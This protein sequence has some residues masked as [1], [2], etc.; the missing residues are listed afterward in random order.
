[1]RTT[2]GN[3]GLVG[4]REDWTTLALLVPAILL[5]VLAAVFWPVAGLASVGIAVFLFVAVKKPQL[6]SP[7]LVLASLPFMR[8]NI[9]GGNYAPVSTALCLVA[10]FIA[11]AADSFKT[12][13]SKSYSI[14]AIGVFAMYVWVL[15]TESVFGDDGSIPVIVQGVI[16]T[17]ITV[18]AVGVVIADP[19][20]RR[21]IGLGFVWIM[22]ALCASYVVTLVVGV[23]LGFDRLAIGTFD[24]GKAG[25]VGT[26]YLPFTPSVGYQG[27]GGIIFPRF[28]GLG[29]EPGWM[30]MFAGVAILLWSKVGRIKYLGVLALVIGMLGAFS[31][32]GFGAFVVAI[33]VAW[34]TKKP[35]TGDQ[36]SHF[37]GM[38]FKLAVLGFAGWLAIAAPVF[39]LM[40]KGDVNAASLDDRTQATNAGIA[41]VIDNPFGGVHAANSEA[42]NLVAALAPFGIPYF[43]IVIAALVLPRFRHAAKGVTTAPILL[44]LITLLLSQPA[45]DST[46]VFI[47]VGLIYTCA[48]PEMSEILPKRKSRPAAVSKRDIGYPRSTH[49]T[50]RPET[51]AASQS[52]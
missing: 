52:V 25:W 18:A 28:T 37:F 19:K 27:F 3:G 47:L 33:V 49:Q 42:I 45:G 32:A 21:I 10:A 8:P 38:L 13:F 15:I 4:T 40:A 35:K 24:I 23:V 36:A 48:L 50:M 34:M 20:R 30:S 22:V 31:T 16:T 46:F 17:A 44:I 39:G 12:R 29:R 26:L 41:A 9:L 7:L 5:S 51:H 14:V 1:M 11:L 43:L 6:I 2:E